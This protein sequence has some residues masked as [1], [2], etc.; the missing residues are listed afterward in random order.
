MNL[1]RT[2]IASVYL[3]LCLLLGG[4]SAGG[5]LANGVLQV[6]AVLIIVIHVWARGAPELARDGRWLIGLFIAFAAI[7]AAQLIPLPFDVWS[8][9]PGRETTL[10][11]LQLIGASPDAMPAS[12][13][14]RRTFS[15][16]LWLLPPAAMFLVATRLTRD[17]RSMAARVL[18]GFAVLSIAFGAVQMF[19]GGRSHLYT[20][21]TAGRGVGFFANAN[22]LA[23]LLLC[24]LPFTRRIHGACGSEAWRQQ[25]RGARRHLRGDCGIH[26]RRRRAKRFS[27][28]LR[29]PDPH[30]HTEFHPVPTIRGKE[31]R[32]QD[33]VGRRSR[34]LAGGRLSGRGP[35]FVRTVRLQVR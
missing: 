10:R 35:V 22:H 25:R 20:I 27:C 3:A 30:R 34:W 24:S 31:G 33:L 1:L 14:P 18:L 13:D 23:T 19:N 28:G 15:S 8:G 21:T 17:E 11:S 29:S 5:A 7:A 6:L 12:L 4:A 26:R 2:G 16:L 32:H 9:L